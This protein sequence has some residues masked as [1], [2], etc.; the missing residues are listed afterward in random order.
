MVDPARAKFMDSIRSAGTERGQQQHEIAEAS[1]AITIDVCIDPTPCGEDLQDVTE[2]GHAITV[3]V[4]RTIVATDHFFHT[5]VIDARFRDGVVGRVCRLE[6][7][8]DLG[9]RFN[10]IAHPERDRFPRRAGA[11]GGQS[12]HFGEGDPVVA[13]DKSA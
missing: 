5:E 1:R 9:R 11:G 6:G 4:G 13:G 10:P 7:H 3:H 2:V 12:G 8:D